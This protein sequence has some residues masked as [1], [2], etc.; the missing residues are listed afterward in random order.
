MDRWD[1]MHFLLAALDAGSFSGAARAL[2]VEQ[3][4]ISRRVAALEA[5]LGAPLFERTARGLLPT[6]LAQS[7]YPMIKAAQEQLEHATALAQGLQRAPSGRVRLTMTETIAAMLIAPNLATLRQ[8]LPHISLELH[9][10]TRALELRRREADIALRFFEPHEP[11]LLCKVVARFEHI[12]AATPAHLR[13][14]GVDPQ[15]PTACLNQL[16]WLVPD[17]SELTA[18]SP[19]LAWHKEHAT[20][21]R[22][23]ITTSYGLILEAAR[24][25]AGAALVPRALVAQWGLLPLNL[26]PGPTLKLWLVAHR[27]V[28]QSPSVWAVWRWLERELER[29][30]ASTP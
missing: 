2:S 19:E 20:T 1:D 24:C 16:D 6:P 5:Q 21:K 23:L 17:D 28:R 14:K 22:A 11:E 29:M 7:L 18:P 30:Q 10:G 8:E 26:P 12:P 9:T 15:D 27:A 13:A 3:S 25:G 4:T